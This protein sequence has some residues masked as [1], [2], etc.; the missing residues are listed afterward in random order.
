MGQK[1]SVL[2]EFQDRS[3]VQSQCF[4]C[5]YSDHTSTFVEKVSILIHLNPHCYVSCCVAIVTVV[6]Y[7]H[8]VLLASCW[9]KMVAYRKSVVIYCPPPNNAVLHQILIYHNWV[10]VVPS[11]WLL[12]TTGAVTSCH[13][14]LPSG[15]KGRHSPVVSTG[16]G[17]DWHV[18][19][20]TSFTD[21]CFE[22]PPL[23]C[24]VLP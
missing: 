10:S 19:P 7:I 14:W 20:T 6:F 8:N 23:P 21:C 9:C 2:R 3:W 18:K 11:A 17:W 22:L 24:S 13:N 12:S 16:V 15:S 5:C 4:T 1:E